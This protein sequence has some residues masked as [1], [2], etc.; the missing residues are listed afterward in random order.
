[1]GTLILSIFNQSINDKIFDDS[2]IK[3]I[4][5]VLLQAGDGELSHR[6]THI[7]ETHTLQELAWSINTLLDQ[8]EQFIRDISASITAANEG[9]NTRKIPQKGYHGDFRQVIPELN[10]AIESISSSY[11]NAQKSAMSE[12]F[13]QNSEGGI[14]KGLTIIQ[15]DIL[16][17]LS[18][19]EKISLSTQD[20]ATQSSSSQAVVQEI[21]NKIE[22]LIQL[23]TN[24]NE[25]IATLNERT[26]EITTVVDLIKDIAEQTNLLA[27]NA[28]IEA[29]RAGEHGR[30]FAVVADEVRKLAERTQ[31]ATQEIT[32]T[33]N[34]LKQEASDIQTNSENITSIAMDSQDSV[35][36]FYDTLNNFANN[37]STAA[38]EAKYMSDYLYTTLVKVDHIIFKHN[39]YTAI[40]GHE[41]DVTASFDDH[42]SCRLGKWYVAEGKE[43]FGKTAAYSALNTP[44]T[45]LHANALTALSHIK[46]PN[47]ITLHK[48]SIIQ[49]M[50]TVGKETFKLF[51]LFKEM[52]KQANPDVSM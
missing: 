27:L 40:L 42:T 46:E 41:T 17:N 5:T 52:V 3:Q 2:L 49:N 35:A 36:K 22:E 21:I 32:I 23:I 26:D 33:T 15:D 38:N 48:N 4:R 8:T 20:T 25:S 31:K 24:S 39:I 50:S 43:M 7:D 30:G 51:E 45:N 29:A 18:I 28:A 10:R 44:H 13:N 37:A 6:I 9:I 16:Q 47:Y 19:L 12:E 14:F 1:M 11:D 34:T